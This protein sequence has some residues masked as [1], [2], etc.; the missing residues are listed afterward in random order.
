MDVGTY[1]N[2][3]KAYTP[4]FLHLYDFLVIG[5]FTRFF[6]KCEGRHYIDIYR[7]HARRRHADIGVGTGYFLDHAGL[8]ESMQQIALIDLN[9]NCLR[10]TA[11]RLQRYAP[12][13]H[14]R[15]AFRPI[16]I[17]RTVDSICIGG[18]IH[19]VPGTMRDKGR[20]FDAI[21][22]LCAPGTTLFGYTLIGSGAP[23]SWHARILMG[24]M[25]W[26]Q[27][28]DNG[29]DSVDSLREELSQ[30]FSQVEVWLVGC[31]AFFTAKNHKDATR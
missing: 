26:L 15:N 27:V 3:I 4:F 6:W 24:F 7:R 11:Q 5:I 29:G 14:V 13:C 20:I 12:D 30:R 22:P 28:V 2:G 9:R 23:M 1:R 16:S 8:D 21:A 31:N 17:G 18:L 25:N 10:Y 19:C